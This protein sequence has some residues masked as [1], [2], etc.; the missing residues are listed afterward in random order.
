MFI[1]IARY[2]LRLPDSGSLKD[3]RAVLRSVTAVIHKK[4]RCSVAE[5]DHQDLYQRAAMGIAVVSGSAFQARKVLQQVGRVI[6]VQPGVEL[7]GVLEDVM[8][9]EDR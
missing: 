5:V 6:E 7:L 9:Q 3:K 2:E 4:F 1:G 8:S